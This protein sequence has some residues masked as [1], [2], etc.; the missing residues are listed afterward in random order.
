MG[1]KFDAV[2]YQRTARKKLSE[3]YLSNPESFLRELEKKYGHLRKN[4]A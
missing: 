4:R 3:M 2:Q 1:K